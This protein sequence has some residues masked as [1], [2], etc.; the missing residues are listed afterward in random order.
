[1]KALGEQKTVEGLWSCLRSYMVDAGV[2]H[3]VCGRGDGDGGGGDGRRGS[4]SESRVDRWQL[5]MLRTTA[6]I[7]S[8]A[9]ISR[10]ISPRFRR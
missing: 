4:G 7:R 3:G 5:G 6:R 1:M 9:R 2:S 8:I 10:R